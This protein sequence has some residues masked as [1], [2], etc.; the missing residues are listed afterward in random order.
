MIHLRPLFVFGMFAL[1]IGTLVACS[2]TPSHNH[3]I[4]VIDGTK[5]QSSTPKTQPPPKPAPA[6]VQQPQANTPKPQIILQ[7]PTPT[8]APVPEPKQYYASFGEWKNDFINRAIAQGYSSNSVYQ[9]MNGASLNSQVISLDGKQAEFAKMPW[10]YIESAASKNRVSQGKAQVND[11]PSLLSRIESTYKVP[12]EI[13]V[14]IWG[15]ESSYGTGTGNMNLVNALSSLAFDGRRRAFAEGEL[16][17]M[18]AMVERGDA[19]QY[20]LKGSWAGGMGHTQFIPSTWL[21]QGVDGNN[22]GKKHPWTI[23]DA[24]S[25]TANYL[26]NSGWIYGVDAYY[27]V[28][29]PSQFDYQLIGQKLPLDAW[30]NHGILPASGEYFAGQTPA[31][32]WLPAGINGPAL[33]TTPNFEVIKVYNNSSNYALGVALLGKRIGNKNGINASWP[34]HERPLSTSQ[35]KQLQQ[36]LTSRGYD[37]GGTD[38][39]AG[40]NTRRAFARWQADNGKV[41]DGFISQ[42]SAGSLLW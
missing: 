23:S 20:E 31:Q 10:E 33:L 15:L 6:P 8:V 2:S 19:G 39:I 28:R 38:G 26:H 14:A 24:L 32:L 40:A 12:K 37:T 11:Y 16:L 34:R 22:D 13:V 4:E 25:S 3:P 35:I 5:P 1:A 41:P 36:N 21:K 30:K 7:S 18:M 27:E 29:L 42:N 17:A 9:L